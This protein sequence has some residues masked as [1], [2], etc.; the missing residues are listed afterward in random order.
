[1]QNG[2]LFI[3]FAIITLSARTG[4]R[5]FPLHSSRQPHHEEVEPHAGDESGDGVDEV[6]GLNIN[7][8]AAEEDI[9]RKVNEEQTAVAAMPGKEHADGAHP[10]MAAG[11][12]GCGT[13]AGCLGILDKLI[14][15]T[16]GIARRGQARGVGE[17]VVVDV[18]EHSLGYRFQSY[19][20]IIERGTDNGEEYIYKVID[21]ERGEDDELQRTLRHL[22]PQLKA[23]VAR[24][25]WDMSEYFHIWNEESDVIKCALKQLGTE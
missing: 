6:V 20:M 3:P 7:C 8:G 5:L 15:H 25:L 2:I 16:V 21:E 4:R 9:E 22:R 19:G 13:L 17:E 11:E 18:G 24:D 12:G 14:E 10:D 23:L 1:M